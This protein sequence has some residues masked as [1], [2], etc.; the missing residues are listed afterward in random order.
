MI[1]LKERYDSDWRLF[2]TES[3]K[4]VPN[5]PEN[6]SRAMFCLMVACEANKAQKGRDERYSVEEL[7]NLYGTVCYEYRHL[8]KI[9]LTDLESFIYRLDSKIGLGKLANDERFVRLSLCVLKD[10]QDEFSQTNIYDVETLKQDYGFMDRY[11][12]AQ[13]KKEELL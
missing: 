2:D 13:D 1:K 8:K 7:A 9:T 6:R 10:Q 3:G 5:T 4:F 11:I 12:F